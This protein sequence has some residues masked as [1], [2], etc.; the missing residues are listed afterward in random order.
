[1][2]YTTDGW[3]TVL[4]EIETASADMLSEL[5]TREAVLARTGDEEGGES[6][7]KTQT[8]INARLQKLGER[9][10]AAERSADEVGAEI[11]AAEND[12][13]QWHEQV[14]A[15]HARLTAFARG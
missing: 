10:A 4:A 12:L 14:H 13:R 6:F 5:D 7:R 9:I 3:Q 11:A 8:R 2:T 1:M 15:L